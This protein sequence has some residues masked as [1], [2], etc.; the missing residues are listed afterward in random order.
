MS[1][2]KACPFCGE[3]L[4]RFTPDPTS[5][6]MP[7]LPL[8][9]CK[10]C[11]WYREGRNYP[12]IEAVINNRPTESALEAQL[13]ALDEYTAGLEIRVL[14]GDDTIK[15][16]NNLLIERTVERDAVLVIVSVYEKNG[17]NID[18]NKDQKAEINKYRDI[19]LTAPTAPPQPNSA[20]G[21]ATGRVDGEDREKDK[22]NGREW[23][24]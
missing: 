2:L 9:G 20:D 18:T 19:L 11:H 12:E 17:A 7:G 22:E 21:H 16:L 1:E 15:N 8:I 3:E 4:I 13:T 14:K 24:K 6:Q 5:S 23:E 10:H